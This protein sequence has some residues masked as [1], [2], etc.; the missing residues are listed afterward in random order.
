MVIKQAAKSMNKLKK[1]QVLVSTQVERMCM[2][3]LKL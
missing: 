3:V 1:Q 2:R